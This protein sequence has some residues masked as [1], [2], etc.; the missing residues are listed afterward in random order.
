MSEKM[1]STAKDAEDTVKTSK[2]KAAKT[3]KAKAAKMAQTKAEKTAKASESRAA[4]GKS[5]K[6]AKASESR[7]VEKDEKKPSEDRD[8]GKTVKASSETGNGEKF[9]EDGAGGKTVK[10]SSKTGAGGKTVKDSSEIGAGEKSSEDGAGGKTVKASSETGAEKKYSGA[11]AGKKSSET[12]AGKGVP[13]WETGKISA[14]T[15]VST[16]ELAVV[17]GITARYV[18][19]LTEDGRLLKS[20]R[21][22]Y[23]LAQ[24]VQAYV[25]MK[26]DDELDDDDEE[27]KKKD[28]KTE[29]LKRESEAKYKAAKAAIAEMDAEERKGKMHRS[30]DVA[31]MT[32]DLIFTVRGALIA[33]PGRLAVDVI[34]IEDAAVASEIIRREVNLVMEELAGYEYDPAKYQE[35]V[36]ERLK[37]EAELTGG[38]EDA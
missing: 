10:A 13:A 8:G 6:T 16:S 38:D 26:R 23:P 20:G 2:A 14:A 15:E 5:E 9:C 35:R 4:V 36:R 32:A 37:L 22:R 18:R 24:S 3:S 33:L 28:K 12:G 11:G 27:T 34:G 31:A 19:Q 7:A 30:E 17:L 25:S 29:R 21:G 1:S